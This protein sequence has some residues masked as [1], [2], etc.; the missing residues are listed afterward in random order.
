[1]LIGLRFLN[2]KI[3]NVGKRV[4]SV[5]YMYLQNSTKVLSVGLINVTFATSG[6]SIGAEHS[7]FSVEYVVT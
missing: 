4:R 6:G 3:R 7:I 2:M 1:M 5:Y